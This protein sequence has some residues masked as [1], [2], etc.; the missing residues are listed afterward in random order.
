MNIEENQLFI[1]FM[2]GHFLATVHR[3]RAGGCIT[4]AIAVAVAVAL[5]LMLL[6]T[7]VEIFS[8]LLNAEFV[9]A[10]L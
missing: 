10:V 9:C 4:V 2:C 5:G 7:H 1:L 6:F 3:G 8:G